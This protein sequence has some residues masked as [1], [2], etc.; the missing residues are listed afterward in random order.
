[1]KVG[2]IGPLSGDEDEGFR[3][4]TARFVEHLGRRH[5]ILPLDVGGISSPLFWKRMRD[6]SPDV[7]HYMTA[8]TFS[9]FLALK[10]ARFLSRTETK[11][12]MSALHP[13]CLPV[14]RN[15][16]VR[17][18]VSRI[19][20]DLIVTQSSEAARLLNETGAGVRF[21]PHG[22]DTD[23]FRPV[24]A[25]EKVRLREKYD[26]D[27]EVS[28]LL[29]VG[30]VKP[31][32]GL[33]HLLRLQQTV[34]DCQVVIVG[35][36]RFMR[37]RKYAAYLREHGCIVMEG[38]Y[39]R[40][41]E[42]YQLADCYVFPPG[43]TLFLPL[44]VME[45]MACNLPV[46]TAPFDG[47]MQF[48]PEGKG[49]FVARFLEEYSGYVRLALDGRGTVATRE[50]VLPCSWDRVADEVSGMYRTLCGGRT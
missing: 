23:R 10:A 15:P 19:Q 26:L 35:S 32:R 49:L 3:N 9:S 48:F 16:V 13:N 22:V 44:T 47:V 28:V 40:I 25:G 37:D 20:P 14:L 7:V 38:Y 34:P 5:D 36:P 31:D 39:S 24:P 27:R 6:F 11:V 21:L 8:P 12:V 18:L 17:A 30:H 43:K 4:V 29:H 2:I 46:V 33:G 50:T 1:V 42:L 45:A 41:E